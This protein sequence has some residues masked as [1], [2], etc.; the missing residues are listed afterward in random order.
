MRA[1]VTS[2]PATNRCQALSGVGMSSLVN[3][4]W[5]QAHD[6]RK[7]KAEAQRGLTAGEWQGWGLHHPAKS[8]SATARRP[9]RSC[10]TYSENQQFKGKR[11]KLP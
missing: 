10:A 1:T 2:G 7:N 6:G 11:N 4:A 5:H 9:P 3:Q 8:V